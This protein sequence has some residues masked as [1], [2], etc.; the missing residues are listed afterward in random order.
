MDINDY[1]STCSLQLN[2]HNLIAQMSGDNNKILRF[3]PSMAFFVLGFRD[4]LEISKVANPKTKNDHSLNKHCSEDANHWLWFINDVNALAAMNIIDGQSFDNRNTVLQ[5][6]WADANYS[7]RLHTYTIA[8]Y[9]LN[10]KSTEE[11]LVIIDCLEAAF[12]V[13]MSG[14]NQHTQKN[15]LYDKLR[16]FGRDHHIDEASHSQG[17]WL[18]VDHA[19]KYTS[20]SSDPMLKGTI[21]KIFDGFNQCFD[22]WFEAL[23][24]TSTEVQ[25]QELAEL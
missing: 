3:A 5:H 9:L 8:G 25:E 24:L 23:E 14:L 12:S 2:S 18:D 22:V 15:G 19:K 1:I 6:L 13:F 7:V 11:K 17:S 10:A 21:S 20:Y 4:L 16:Y